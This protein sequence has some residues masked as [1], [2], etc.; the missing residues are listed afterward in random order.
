[1]GRMIIGRIAMACVGIGR[2]AIRPYEVGVN[3]HD[4]MYVIRH[5]YKLAQFNFPPYLG[6]FNPFIADKMPI[7]I[8]PH[9]ILCD[10]SEQ[11]FPVVGANGDKICAGPG[12]VISSQTDG[13]A[14]VAAGI[15]AIH[16][17]NPILSR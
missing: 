7:F 2:M 9:F 10:F 11:A 17:E 3:N 13:T 4:S 16:H 1:M 6:G 12:I 15:I 8:H 5:G 14:M